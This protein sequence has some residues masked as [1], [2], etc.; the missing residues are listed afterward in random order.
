M[1][2]RKGNDVVEI[3]TNSQLGATVVTPNPTVSTASMCT[4]KGGQWSSA[5]KECTGIDSA[6]CSAIGGKFNE[7]AS[8]CRNDPQAQMCTMQCVQVCDFK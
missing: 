2:F 6:A 4:D 3:T 7:C 5:F 1:I 8:A